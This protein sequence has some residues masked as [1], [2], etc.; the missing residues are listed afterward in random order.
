[1][2]SAGLHL[3][4]RRYLGEKGILFGVQQPTPFSD[5]DRYDLRFG[6]RTCELK[7]FL[8]SRAS[9]WQELSGDPRLALEAPALVPLDRHTSDTVKARDLYAFAFVGARVASQ[10]LKIQGQDPLHGEYWMHVMPASWQGA[11]RSVPLGPV[12]LKAEAASG[13]SFELGGRD[14][15][16]SP[17]TMS[18]SPSGQRVELPEIL[19]SLNHICVASSPLRTLGPPCTRQPPEARDRTWR[20]A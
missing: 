5:P 3:A 18:A 15:S 17:V 6:G 9:Q 14:R 12:V 19:L 2:A 1:M 10:M 16:G 4:F 11:Q 8:I 7:T 13:I 20:L